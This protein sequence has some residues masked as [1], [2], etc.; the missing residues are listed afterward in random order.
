MV[1]QG[2]PDGAFKGAEAGASNPYDRTGPKK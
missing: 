2:K 1:R